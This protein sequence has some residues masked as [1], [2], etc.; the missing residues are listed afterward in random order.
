[1]VE[2]ALFRRLLH[3]F[4]VHHG[5]F[6]IMWSGLAVQ[7]ALQVGVASASTPPDVGSITSLPRMELDR[8]MSRIKHPKQVNNR[9]SEKE[10]P[11]T[12]VEILMN[13]GV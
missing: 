13:V 4:A 1:M 9:K 8:W 12:H 11:V 10:T 6:P 3:S 7:I 5:R 2:V